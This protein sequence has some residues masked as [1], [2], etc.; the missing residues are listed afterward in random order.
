MTTIGLGSLEVSRTYSQVAAATGAN[1]E[2]T[3]DF[4]DGS[5][6]TVG[7]DGVRYHE[8]RVATRCLIA[9]RSDNINW[10]RGQGWTARGVPPGGHVFT[11]GDVLNSFMMCAGF[12]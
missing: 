11:I 7:L 3:D 4:G 5:C 10:W 1:V 9:T 2:A 8:R 12:L 6:I